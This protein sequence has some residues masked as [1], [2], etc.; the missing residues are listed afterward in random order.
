MPPTRPRPSPSGLRGPTR[1]TLSRSAKGSSN[2]FDGVES[3]F[4]DGRRRDDVQ[5]EKPPLAPERRPREGPYSPP[6]AA[7]G[8]G[9]SKKSYVE[10]VSG[11]PGAA[12]GRQAR[13]AVGGRDRRGQRR[14]AGDL[15]LLP[16]WV[17]HPRL[18]RR[19][20]G[21]GP[22]AVDPGPHDHSTAGPPAWAVRKPHAS[23]SPR[24]CPDH[25]RHAR[26]GTV[27][28]QRPVDENRRQFRLDLNI[29][30]AAIAP[31]GEFAIGVN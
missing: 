1:S 3:L 29:G 20:L 17:G 23:G 28:D 15:D 6:G 24:A 5:F 9:R 2:S 8:A 12:W 27:R 18:I 10:G 31:E 30:V 22:L 26:P 4:R 16:A 21:R 25:P 14:T 13:G 11:P 19:T 7:L